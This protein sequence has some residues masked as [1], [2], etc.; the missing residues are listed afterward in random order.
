MT[1]GQ[2]LY[3]RWSRREWLLRRLYDLVFLGRQASLRA[4]SA[5]LLELSPGDTVLDVGCGAGI[6]L[7]ALRT[8]VGPRGR[9]FAVDYSGGMVRRARERVRA[10]GWENVAVARADAHRL[11]LPPETADAAYATMSVSA[12][13]RPEAVFAEL[14]R[15][16]RPGGRVGLLDARPFQERPWT[17]LNRV[18][19]PL[20]RWATDWKPE[21]D[22]LGAFR[23]A[24]T[25]VR[26][27]EHYAGTVVV[28]GG[29]V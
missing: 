23:E 19:V 16:L 5:D 4:A 18:L 17:V 14:R 25:D 13:E 2:R 22:F 20:S 1:R 8:R 12:M 27:S 26:V 11:P 24:F 29:R 21:A 15:V 9:V 7:H 10:A 3:D 28:A 6:N